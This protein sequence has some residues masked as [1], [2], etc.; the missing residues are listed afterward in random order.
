M[1]KF[2]RII[3]KI[4]P[5]IKLLI[6]FQIEMWFREQSVTEKKLTAFSYQLLSF[7]HSEILYLFGIFDKLNSGAIKSWKTY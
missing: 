1:K 2:A 3:E 7:P 6:K 5:E 4:I